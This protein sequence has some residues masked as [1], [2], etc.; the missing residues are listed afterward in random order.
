[1][2]GPNIVEKLQFLVIEHLVPSVTPIRK[3]VNKIEKKCQMK[4]PRDGPYRVT[5]KISDENIELIDPNEEMILG[6][7]AKF[8]V[9]VNRTKI[10]NFNDD[11]YQSKREVIQQVEVTPPPPP[12][13]RG[14]G[15]PKKLV[16]HTVIVNERKMPGKR[17]G[18]P[19]K[20]LT[21][22]RHESQMTEAPIVTSGQTGQKFEQQGRKRRGRPPK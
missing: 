20:A 4:H 17:K 2:R 12:A 9:H 19:R 13:K 7:K 3:P 5:R 22:I 15:R 8:I 18:R 21:R 6:D 14:R 1:M 11:Y 16:E 10:V